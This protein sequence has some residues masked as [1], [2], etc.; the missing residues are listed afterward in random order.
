[1]VS[2]GHGHALLTARAPA[3]LPR[4]RSLRPGGA[5]HA[6]QLQEKAIG[7]WAEADV[8]G[9]VGELS[10]SDVATRGRRGARGHECDSQGT[11]EGHG[12]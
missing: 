7:S 12:V 1:M 11:E 10:A 6:H 8:D 2:R 5:E 4:L 3:A 9:G